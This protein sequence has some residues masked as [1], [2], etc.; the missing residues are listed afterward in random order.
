MIRINS[1]ELRVLDNINNT[2]FDA[3]QGQIV[4]KLD[5]S[6]HSKTISR[7]QHDFIFDELERIL[8][9][10]PADLLNVNQEYKDYCNR[11]RCTN[12]AKGL[13]GIFN[14]KK[15]SNKNTKPYSAYDLAAN[16]DVRVCPYCNRQY[17]FTVVTVS[18][19][20]SRPEFD[21]F[22]SQEK[23]P[24]LAL[25]FFNLI[26]SCK[27][28]NSTLKHTKQFTLT[29]NIHP[30]LHGFDEAARFNYHANDSRSAIGMGTN[31][32]ITLIPVDD[33][34]LLEQLTNN[35]RIFKLEDIY[36]GHR[37]I[38][39][40]IVRKFYM[41]DGRYL[42]TLFKSF[43]QIGGYEELYRLAFGNFLNNSD[44]D[45]RILSKLTKDI[46]NQLDFLLPLEIKGIK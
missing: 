27:I 15:F 6:F 25:S 22:F 28:C 30:Y 1:T 4:E 20:I 38:V 18:N 35:I 19:N 5:S 16:L 43:P 21:H 7:C 32:K 26:P 40:E 37:D 14:Y 39:A 24:L 31:M 41:S 36:Q 46:V 3:M 17:T 10:E 29:R 2:H 44:L 11:H 42:E 23:F 8:K 9:G 33:H 12:I 13:K 45:Q 34:A